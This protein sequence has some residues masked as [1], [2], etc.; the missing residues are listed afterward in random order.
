M[1]AIKL[2]S[3]GD[4]VKVVDRKTDKTAFGQVTF[5]TN[6]GVCV[7]IGFDDNCVIPVVGDRYYI[8]YLLEKA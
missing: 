5:I 4:V 8:D 3:V 2:L 6:D 7:R 1:V